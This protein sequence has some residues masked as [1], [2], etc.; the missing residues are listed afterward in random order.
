MALFV[1][2]YDW[3]MPIRSLGLSVTDFD[4]DYC[5]QFDFSKTVEKREKLEKIDTAVD[6]LKDRYGTTASDVERY[7]LIQSF[8]ISAL[9]TTTA[10][11]LYR[12]FNGKTCFGIIYDFCLQF[13][14][15][16][17]IITSHIRC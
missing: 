9:M 5:S 1:I 16:F 12:R 13:S 10:F 8:R 11:T 4:F 14:F 3:K 2:N 6:A 15:L 7:Y 17:D